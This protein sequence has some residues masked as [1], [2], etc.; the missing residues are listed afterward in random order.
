MKVSYMYMYMYIHTCTCT[1]TYIHVHVHVFVM[2][3]RF[4]VFDTHMITTDVSFKIPRE[5]IIYNNYMYK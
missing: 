1:C 3:L 5:I 2:L 4:A